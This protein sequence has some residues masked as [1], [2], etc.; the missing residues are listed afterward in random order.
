MNSHTKLTSITHFFENEGFSIIATFFISLLA[1]VFLG[2][3]FYSVGIQMVF[4]YMLL[5]TSFLAA[6]GF[7][8]FKIRKNH[9]K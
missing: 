7:S 6:I 1:L 9:I 4:F 2:F 5:G 3:F 8:I